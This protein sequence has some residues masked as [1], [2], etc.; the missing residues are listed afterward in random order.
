MELGSMCTGRSQSWCW[1]HIP[2]VTIVTDAESISLITIIVKQTWNAENP[3]MKLVQGPA[4]DQ[5]IRFLLNDFIGRIIC[6][7]QNFWYIC[8]KGMI[9]L[10]NLYSR[11]NCCNGELDYIYR[12]H[13]SR[14]CQSKSQTFKIW[15]NCQPYCDMSWLLFL[16]LDNVALYFSSNACQSSVFKTYLHNGCFI[17]NI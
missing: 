6:Q 7:D 16:Y 5:L 12:H 10:Y 9:V 13:I 17:F 4:W 11:L 8:C 2:T 14:S 3:W 1:I 15:L